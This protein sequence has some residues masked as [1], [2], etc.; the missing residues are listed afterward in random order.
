ME[1]RNSEVTSWHLSVGAIASRVPDGVQV[2]DL[3]P[4]TLVARLRSFTLE[5][6]AKENLGGADLLATISTPLQCFRDAGLRLY[7]SFKVE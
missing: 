2:R 1:K 6:T 5:I 4:T 7:V 3:H